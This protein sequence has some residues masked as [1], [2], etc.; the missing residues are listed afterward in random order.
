[1]TEIKFDNE[2]W[3]DITNFERIYQ[4]SNKGNVRSLERYV[5]CKSKNKPN[6]IKECILKQRLD[7]YGYLIVNLKKNQKSHI[8]KIHRLVAEAFIENKQNLETV[9]H[10]NGI[11]TDN[12]V[13]NL[14]WL[15][16]GDNARHRTK[17]LLV[18]PKLS[19]IEVLYIF[20]NLDKKTKTQ[21]AKDLN[22][23]RNTVLDIING[24]KLYIEELLCK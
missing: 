23:C 11:K 2:V 1:M 17:K 18:K 24:K 3:K 19:K 22:V 13:E 6:I 5:Y 15:S 21:I 8:R 7:K 12:R 9:N 14:E 4:V 10:I 20:N 16:F